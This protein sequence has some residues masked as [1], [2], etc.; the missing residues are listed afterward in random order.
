MLLGE[1]LSLRDCKKNSMTAGERKQVEAGE[2]V[3]GVVSYDKEC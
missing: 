3:E 1:V 2:I